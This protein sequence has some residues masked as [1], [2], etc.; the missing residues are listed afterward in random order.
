MRNTEIESWVADVAGHTK[1]AAIHW[2]DGS[3]AEAEEL[4]KL[5]QAE[6]PRWG[7]LVKKSG[8]QAN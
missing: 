5:M 4:T 8:A 1:P 7:A 2:C 6:I 3:P